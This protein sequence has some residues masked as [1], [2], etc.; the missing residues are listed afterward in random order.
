MAFVAGLQIAVVERPISLFI[1]ARWNHL[2][3]SGGEL[4]GAR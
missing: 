4:L 1:Y 3:F 2:S